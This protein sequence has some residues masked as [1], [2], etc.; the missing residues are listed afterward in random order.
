MSN[1]K[2]NSK[3][4]KIIQLTVLSI[5]SLVTAIIFLLYLLPI[6]TYADYIYYPGVIKPDIIVYQTFYLNFGITK[7]LIDVV[8]SFAF[9]CAE[10]VLLVLAFALYKT[11]RKYSNIFSILAA[12]MFI[13]IIIMIPISFFVFKL[14]TN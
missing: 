8:L 1:Y 6:Y 11:K 13:V 5:I 4:L 2:A 7:N 9:L 10:I 3:N 12:V 14:P